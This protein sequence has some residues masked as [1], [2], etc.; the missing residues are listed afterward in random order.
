MK[1][2]K[3]A[4]LTCRDHLLSKQ[5]FQLRYDKELEMLKTHPAPKE[6]DLSLYY[7]SN[8]YVSHTDTKKTFTDT[9][10]HLVKKY[11]L[12]QKRSLINRFAK[13]GGNLLDIGCG[14]GDFLM[15]CQQHGWQVSGI[16]PNSR[17][18]TLAGQKLASHTTLVETIDDLEEG[19]FKVITLWHVLEHIPNLQS[20]I[21]TLQQRLAPD[22]VLIVAVPN[23]KSADAVFYKQYWAAFDVP[24]HLWHFSQKAIRQLFGKQEMDVI[25]TYPMCFDAFYVSLLSEQYRTGKNNFI[26]AFLIGIWSNLKAMYT[27]EYSSL[28]YIIKN[29]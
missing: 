15:T 27:K 2:Q 1:D 16:E 9:L 26:R 28:I 21:A 18:R 12:V 3:E 20:F 23:Y 4:Y 7:Q 19:Q 17:A 13:G 6:K 25:A 29:R 5:S 11:T 24:R 8:N 10:Y 14:T 22:G